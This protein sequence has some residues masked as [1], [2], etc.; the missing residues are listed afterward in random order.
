MTVTLHGLARRWWAGELGAAGTTL[1]VLLAPAEAVY[2]LGVAA[3]NRAY[4]AGLLPI[5]RA[6]VPAISVGNTAV[7]GTGKTPFTNWLALRLRAQGH[8]PAIVHGGYSADEPAL[9]RA[10]SPD[11]PVSVARDR[12]AAA[13][14]AAAVG[15]NVVVLDDG[16]QHR[17]LERDLDIVL[18]SAERWTG[19]VRLLPRGP[20]RE[21]GRAL[22]R[23]D[24]IVITRKTAPAGTADA[25]AANLTRLT[26]APIVRVHLRAARWR[27]A[28]AATTPHAATGIRNESPSLTAPNAPRADAVPAAALVVS[29]IAEPELFVESV[30]RAGVDITS[31][32]TFP[33]HH[34]YSRTDADRIRV[35]AAGG[36]IVT[37]EKD[38]M[39]LDRW[40]E[41]SVVWLLGQD[42]ILESGAE[43]LDDL[44]SR[45][46]S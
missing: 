12:V 32:L 19:S 44:L 5:H 29:G 13:R 35:A 10:W 30:R 18:V 14:H 1:D 23:A 31:V 3:R 34:A 2:R 33:D 26:R 46:F 20:W 42:V 21:P 22:Q 11:I 38:W 41:D 7:G 36:P 16:F 39:R 43:T 24:L 17:R 27:P 9:H 15:A 6:P 45:V 28:G 4:D 40:L 8:E 25:V 37:T